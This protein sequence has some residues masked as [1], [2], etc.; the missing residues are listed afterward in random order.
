MA[1][2]VWA[3]LPGIGQCQAAQS[4]AATPGQ[5]QSAPRAL[6]A[7]EKQL[8]LDPK[9]FAPDDRWVYDGS[10]KYDRPK[11]RFGG[12][13]VGQ[14]GT[15]SIG[16]TRWLNSGAF[17]LYQVWKYPSIKEA[18][19]AFRSV[20]TLEKPGKFTR[21]TVR[22]LKAGDESRDVSETVVNEKGDPASYHRRVRVRFGA[23]V[24]AVTSSA[25]M[26]AFGPAPAS[27]IRPWLSEAVFDKVLKAAL[28]R[29]SS[30][31]KREIRRP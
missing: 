23:Y 2:V 29:C 16:D 26:K 15:V 8:L 30:L 24:L 12:A 31:I 17:V 11:A 7:D 21:R 1:V 4:S 3:A 22:P 9:L 14:K 27:G 5:T 28:Q 10:D 18:R 19:E 6:T 25:D 20:A 13:T